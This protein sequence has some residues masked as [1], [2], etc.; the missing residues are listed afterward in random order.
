MTIGGGDVEILYLRLS[1]ASPA[2][3]YDPFEEFESVLQ[4]RQQEADEFY[5][6]VTPPSVSPE[7]GKVM[8]Q[9]LAGMLWSKQYYYYDVDKWLKEHGVDPWA[10]SAQADSER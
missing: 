8:R 2:E 5:H 10:F 6:S 4:A 1:R 9:A 7:E 3:L